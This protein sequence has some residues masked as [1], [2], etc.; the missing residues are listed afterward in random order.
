MIE[1]NKLTLVNQRSSLKGTFCN[2]FMFNP[3]LPLLFILVLNNTIVIMSCFIH[4][5]KIKLQNKQYIVYSL[6]YNNRNRL[7]MV[8]V[9]ISGTL[10]SV[11]ILVFI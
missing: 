11:N 5:A 2:Y 9:G 7:F 10:Y 3:F 1:I 4:N 6:A 8:S